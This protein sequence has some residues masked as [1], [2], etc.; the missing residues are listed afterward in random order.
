[1]TMKAALPLHALDD[2]AHCGAPTIIAEMKK[3]EGQH[4]YQIQHALILA[5]PG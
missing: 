2:L 5:L 3:I 4:A 1:M